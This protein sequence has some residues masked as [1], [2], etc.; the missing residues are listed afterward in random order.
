MGPTEE[1]TTDTKLT[2]D[3]PATSETP[4]PTPTAQVRQRRD[5]DTVG[6]VSLAAWREFAKLTK[7]NPFSH[8]GRY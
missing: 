2:T 8:S 6:T 4:Y 3:E 1:L 7:T 5:H